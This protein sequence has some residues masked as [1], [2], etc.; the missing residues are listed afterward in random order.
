M[1]LIDGKLKIITI[2][3]QL[4]AGLEAQVQ[5]SAQWSHPLIDAALHTALMSGVGDIKDKLKAQDIKSVILT[6]P[7]IRLPLRRL[8]SAAHPEVTILAMNEI[9]PGITVEAVG[10]LKVVNAGANQTV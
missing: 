6:S 3:P 9:T 10:V 5:A 2:D 8:L 7:K 4:E 1:I